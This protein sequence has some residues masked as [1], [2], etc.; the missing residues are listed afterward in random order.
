ML[1]VAVE[2]RS[3]VSTPLCPPPVQATCQ[4]VVAEIA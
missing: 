3:T 2:V 4:V 1:T